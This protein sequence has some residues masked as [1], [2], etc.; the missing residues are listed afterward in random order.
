[1]INPAII[2]TQEN[3]YKFKLKYSTLCD[4]RQFGVDMLSGEGSEALQKDPTLLRYVFWKGL[5]AG[6]LKKY[7]QEEA[8]AIFDEVMEEVGPEEFAELIPKALAIKVSTDPATTYVPEQCNDE[9][10]K[11]VLKVKDFRHFFS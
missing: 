6:E 7:S 8:F 3:T 10:L 1:M 11:K 5:E 4:L 2:R 9:K